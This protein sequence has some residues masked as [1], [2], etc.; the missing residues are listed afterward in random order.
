LSVDFGLHFVDFQL[1]FVGFELQAVGFGLQAVRIV[2][3]NKG[4]KLGGE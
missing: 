1:H 4:V 2:E 3:I